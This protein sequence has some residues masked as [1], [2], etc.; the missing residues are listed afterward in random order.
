MLI[1][2]DDDAG[3]N[4]GVAHDHHDA[5]LDHEA[6]CSSDGSSSRAHTDAG[7]RQLLCSTTTRGTRLWHQVT[8]AGVRQ[9]QPQ[10]QPQQQQRSLSAERSASCTPDLLMIC[11]L[12]PMAAFSSTT[13]R[14]SKQFSP[15]GCDG[16]SNGGSSRCVSLRSAGQL[17]HTFAAQAWLQIPLPPE[18]ST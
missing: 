14:R 4:H 9:Q 7:R 2:S 1:A 3:R 6:A 8:E 12:L 18:P 15:A 5:V 13:Q 10:Q 16:S 17:G 11:T